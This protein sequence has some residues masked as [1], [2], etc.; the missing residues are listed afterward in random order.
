VI[1]DVFE[2]AAGEIVQGLA[3]SAVYNGVEGV[4]V[5]W[6]SDFQA[7]QS[8]DLRLSSRRPEAYVRY[9][10]MP[11]DPLTGDPAPPERDDLLVV[12]GLDYRVVTVRPDLE[13]V[14]CY[15]TLKRDG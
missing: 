2:F 6:G 14:G 12:R 13:D 7:V 5:V 4:P 9:A 10:D 3:D 11:V 15:L 8:G 1:R